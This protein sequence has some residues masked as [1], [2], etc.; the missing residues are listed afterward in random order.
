[1]IQSGGF[2]DF[3]FLKKKKELFWSA[4]IITGYGLF[5]LLR[6]GFLVS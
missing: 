2:I 1:M 6:A 5:Q 3:K 4:V